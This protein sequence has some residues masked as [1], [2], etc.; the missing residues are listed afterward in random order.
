M[1]TIAKLSQAPAPAGQAELAL[2]SYNPTTPTQICLRFLSR[3]WS[4]R[5]ILGRVGWLSIRQLVFYHT[6]FQAHKTICSGKSAILSQSLTTTGYPYRTRSAAMGQIR[7][8][9]A[10]CGNTS[11]T[12]ASFK[13]RAVRW[14]NTVP[15]NARTG[16]L[17]SVKRKLKEWVRKNVPLDWG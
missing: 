15:V 11:I 8:G 7:F 10:F 17:P 12:D 3:W 16:N 13:Y 6:V 4:R 9:E 5:K 1:G 2:F 14:Y